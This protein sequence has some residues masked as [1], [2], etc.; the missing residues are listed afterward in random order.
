[1]KISVIICTRN[2]FDDFT[3]TLPSIAAQT[4]L[5]DELIV[6][7]SSDEKRL[8]AYLGSVKLPFSVRYFHTQ[9]GLTLQ[10]NHGIRECVSDLIFF[11]DDDVDLN[12]NY[13]AEVEKV[14]ADDTTKKIGAVGGK[15]V[16]LTTPSARLKIERFAFGVLRFAFGVVGTFNGKFYPSGM[17]SHPRANQPSGFIECLSGCCMAF[18][19]EVLEKATFDEN[20]ARYGLMEDADISKQTLDAGYKIYYQTP[21][22][23]VH[24]E[25]PMNRLNVQQWAEMSVV[26]YDYLF[27][28]SWSRDKWRWLFY[29]WTLL[30][31]FAVNFHSLKGL[32]GTFH[33][34]KKI[35]TTKETKGHKG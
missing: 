29:Y 21:A 14:F 34:V 32:K 2:R 9:P 24:N 30:G 12:T 18:R 8:E 1:M 19:R 31:L 28:K 7:D 27:R 3:K 4:R 23:L 10:R 33:G 17:P 16:E 22:A 15:I 13:L 25:S 5:P 20:L 26:N 6:V 11:F 35:F